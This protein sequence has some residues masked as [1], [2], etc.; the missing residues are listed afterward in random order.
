[1]TQNTDK[2]LYF[3]SKIF[4]GNLT[5]KFNYKTAIK[6]KKEIYNLPQIFSHFSYQISGGELLILITKFNKINNVINEFKILRK[7]N[8]QYKEII[9]FF[10]SHVCDNNCRKLGLLHPRKKEQKKEEDK[11]NNLFYFKF[12]TNIRLCPCCSLPIAKPNYDSENNN[13]TLC[14]YCAQLEVRKMRK[15]LCKECQSTFMYS[16]YYYN[17]AL[18]NYPVICKQCDKSL[19]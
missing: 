17:S 13:M 19:F 15:G 12:I 6:D 7:S 9:E 5:K 16:S 1:M 4:I 8:N 14:D 11:I 2:A 18:E 3:N 10:A